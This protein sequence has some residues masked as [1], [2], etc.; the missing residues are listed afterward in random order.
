MFVE[1]I[2]GLT[3]LNSGNLLAVKLETPADSFEMRLVHH[4]DP[5]TVV[6]TSNGSPVAP[7]QQMA[8]PPGVPGTISILGPNIDTVLIRSPENEVLLLC[9]AAG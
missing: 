7:A 4:A 9:F 6:A 2:A 8:N 5:A 3:G 1:T